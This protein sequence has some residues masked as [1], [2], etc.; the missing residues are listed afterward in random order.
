LLFGVM[1]SLLQPFLLL[2]FRDMEE[3]LQDQI[4]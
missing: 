1:D 2:V 4:L 3:K